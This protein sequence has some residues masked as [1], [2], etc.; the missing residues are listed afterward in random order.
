MRRV[1]DT[2]APLHRIEQIPDHLPADAAGT[3]SHDFPIAG[4]EREAHA[5]HLTVAA[6]DLKAL[7]RPS[8][9]ADAG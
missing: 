7:R 3:P 4:V 5:Y 8:R 2:E 6:E 1:S 9:F